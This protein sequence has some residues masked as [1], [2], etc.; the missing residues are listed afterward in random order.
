[1]NEKS[2]QLKTESM[3]EIFSA[4]SDTQESV[5]GTTINT[6]DVHLMVQFRVHLIIHLELQ[7]KMNFKIYIKVHKRYT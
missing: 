3:S 7:L 5:N 2:C 6:F 4:T 1:M